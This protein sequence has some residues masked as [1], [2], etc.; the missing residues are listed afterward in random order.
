MILSITI[1]V[2]LCLLKNVY[3]ESNSMFLIAFDDINF[4]H[5]Y[6]TQVCGSGS[7][8]CSADT[9]IWLF[10][11]EKSIEPSRFN[12]IT[13]V[14]NTCLSVD[15]SQEADIEVCLK[16]AHDLSKLTTLE[17]YVESTFS[18]ID[19]CLRFLESQRIVIFAEPAVK[20][21]TASIE[22]EKREE[23]RK[24]ILF[25]LLEL[26]PIHKRP[27]FLSTTYDTVYDLVAYINHV[28]D[29]ISEHNVKSHLLNSTKTNSDRNSQF[30]NNT[31]AVICPYKTY[32][33]FQSRI[34]VDN[35]SI[36]SPSLVQYEDIPDE[37]KDEVRQLASQHHKQ[38][39]RSLHINK[40]SSSSSSVSSQE[41]NTVSISSTSLSSD[42]AVDHRYQ[43][44]VACNFSREDRLV[45]NKI[46]VVH[47]STHRANNNN[48]KLLCLLYTYSPNHE[49]VRDIVNTWGSKCDGFLA[50][51]NETDLS[52]STLEILPSPDWVETYFNLWR[53]ICFIIRLV[54]DILMN[55][56][57]YFLLG[58]D[59]LFVIMENLKAVL[60]SRYLNELTS[61]GTKPVFIGRNL[62]WNRYFSFI[63][64]R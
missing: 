10:Q 9:L 5:G 53:K 19:V 2:L 58:G 38:Y 29:D 63:T 23:G 56:Y 13:P 20:S 37:D 41:Y 16:Y 45:L 62:K 4:Y 54:S 39:L 12:C 48:K 24:T 11:S 40:S 14:M 47:N 21:A 33:S 55:D 34:N 27:V 17:L 3:S 7:H 25:R 46:K 28:V 59:D 50:F 49:Y 36:N 6:D 18:L 44:Y 35:D 8:S 61:H 26:L 43:S 60:N 42:S 52:I 32:D 57:D 22:K 31:A 1:N 30:L 51:S 64:G 15:Q